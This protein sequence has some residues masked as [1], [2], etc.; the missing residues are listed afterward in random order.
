MVEHLQLFVHSVR[1]IVNDPATTLRE[2]IESLISHYIDMLIANPNL[3]IF[4]LSEINADPAR[5][6]AKIGVE[7]MHH[8]QVHLV[9]QWQEFVAAKGGFQINPLHILMNVL[10]MTIFPFVAS[11]LLRNRTGMTIEQFNKLMEERKKLIPTWIFTM[12]EMPAS[13]NAQPPAK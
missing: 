3:P 5:L 4:V 1:G 2:K 8:G 11:P 10:S 12:I 13:Q 9:R 6:A 7:K